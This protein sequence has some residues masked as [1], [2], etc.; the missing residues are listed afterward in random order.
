MPPRY[1]GWRLSLAIVCLIAAGVLATRHFDPD[2]SLRRTWQ[3]LL[4]AVEDQNAGRLRDRLDDNYTD[5]WGYTADSLV[6]DARRAFFQTQYLRLIAS[7][8][9]FLRHRDQATITAVLRV[10]ATGPEPVPAARVAINALFSPFVF[11][12]R[13]QARFPWAWK[14]TRCDHP[15]LEPKRFQRNF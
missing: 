4:N 2:R 9:T 7:D 8:A 15:R 12:W 11:E 1:L 14:L 10:D 6:N 5:R 3:E 13:R